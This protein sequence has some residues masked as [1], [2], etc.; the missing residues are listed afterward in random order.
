MAMKVERR[1]GATITLNNAVRSSKT[2]NGTYFYDAE[3]NEVASFGD[4]EV[5]AAYPADAEVAAP[6]TE[7]EA[8]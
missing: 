6:A 3:G 8:Q 4:G 7:G 1:S 5:I 2:G